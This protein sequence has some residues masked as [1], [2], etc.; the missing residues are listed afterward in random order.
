MLTF[1]SPRGENRHLGTNELDSSFEIYAVSLGFERGTRLQF[2]IACWSEISEFGLYVYSWD[3]KLFTRRSNYHRCETGIF[4]GS[5]LRC[6]DYFITI[7][8]CQSYWRRWHLVHVL[9]C[10]LCWYQSPRSCREKKLR[11]GPTTIRNLNGI[12]CLASMY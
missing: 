10:T 11:F 7:R 5:N 8:K 4:D 6:L 9:Y 12:R 1:I 2:F 3:I